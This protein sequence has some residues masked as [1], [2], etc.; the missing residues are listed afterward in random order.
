MRLLVIFGMPDIIQKGPFFFEQLLGVLGGDLLYSFPKHG[1]QW[2]GGLFG[3]GF[4]A[5]R[6]F[7]SEWTGQQSRDSLG[8]G[9]PTVFEPENDVLRGVRAF[10]RL[11]E[12]K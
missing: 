10:L 3:L 5:R 1:I 8:I 11:L 9:I 2:L 12:D 4:G 7:G 6:Y